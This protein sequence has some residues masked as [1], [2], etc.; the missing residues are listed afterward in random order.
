MLGF[1]GDGTF[2]CWEHP[3]HLAP[4]VFFFGAVFQDVDEK[5]GHLL[6]E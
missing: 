3:W 4:W 2:F 5:N 1:D 6:Q